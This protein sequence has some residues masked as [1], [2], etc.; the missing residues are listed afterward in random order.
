MVFSKKEML[1][2]AMI[3]IGG[4]GIVSMMGSGKRG[5]EGTPQPSVSWGERP[6]DTSKEGY[7]Y[8]YNLPREPSIRFPEPP[9]YTALQ[10]PSFSKKSEQA[11][12]SGKAIGMNKPITPQITGDPRYWS[13]GGSKKGSYGGSW[14]GGAAGEAKAVAYTKKQGWIS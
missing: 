3:A 5:E 11:Y 1:I 12:V 6:F 8:I 4:I 10:V 13:N 9:Q 7:T 14:I 2:V